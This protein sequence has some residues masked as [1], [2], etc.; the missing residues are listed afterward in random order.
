MKTVATPTRTRRISGEI[1]AVAISRK[2]FENTD[3]REIAIN[4][5]R[6]YFI[7]ITSDMATCSRML[8]LAG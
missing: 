7:V 3:L 1:L 6:N 8:F 5:Y 2:T 4:V